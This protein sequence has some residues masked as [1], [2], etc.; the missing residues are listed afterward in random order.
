MTPMDLRNLSTGFQQ[1]RIILSA[2]ELGVFEKLCDGKKTAEVLAAK[3]ACNV[4]GMTYLLDAMAAIGVLSKNK[5]RYFIS[6]SLRKYLSP[7]DEL[8]IL[9]ILK[10]TANMWQRWHNLT[11]VVKDGHPMASASGASFKKDAEPFV[12]AMHAIGLKTSAEIAKKCKFAR[13]SKRLLDIG[14]ALGT[15]TLAFL[16]EYPNID[17]TIFDLPDVVELAQKRLVRSKYFSRISFCPGDFDFD[18]L[19]AGFDLALL[20]A[21]I[22]QNSRIE[23]KSLFRENIQVADKEGERFDPRSCYERG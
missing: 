21:I 10:H 1:A 18:D 23:N 12:S 9:P 13:K 15:Y 19:P 11:K 14:G 5:E 4:R 3:C 16:K 6:A 8:S 7:L 20:S 17:A 2:V 22:H